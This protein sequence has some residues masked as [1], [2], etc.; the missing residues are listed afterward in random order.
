MVYLSKVYCTSLVHLYIIELQRRVVK[1]I[2][3]ELLRLIVNILYTKLQL[4]FVKSYILSLLEVYVMV[5]IV[6]IY[7]FPPSFPSKYTQRINGT[8]VEINILSQI[9]WRQRWILPNFS[10]KSSSS[11][12]HLSEVYAEYR[13]SIQEGISWEWKRILPQPSPE[14]NHHNR[15]LLFCLSPTFRLS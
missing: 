14:Y 15:G 11:R 3:E 4:E 10:K 1:K 2:V 12:S 5:C 9:L 13:S 7:Y 6:R 8:L